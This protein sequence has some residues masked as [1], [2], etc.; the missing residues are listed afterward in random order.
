V[1]VGI[2]SDVHAN[3]AALQAAFQ[4]LERQAVQRVLVAGDLIGY[5]AQPNECL[6]ALEAAGAECVLGNH[7]LFVLDRLPPDRFPAV[8]RRSALLTRSLLT[9][10]SRAFLESLPTVL[11]RGRFVMAHG[12]LDDPEEYVTGRRRGR[13]LL[14]RVA[15]DSPGADTLV[16]G[17]THEPMYV[18][19][20]RRAVRARGSVP[21]STGRRLINPGS[22]GQSRQREARPRVRLAVMDEAAGQV[23]YFALDYDVDMSRRALRAHDLPDRC[24]HAPISVRHRAEALVRPV[25]G[26]RGWR[27]AR[28][29]YRLAGAR[30]RD[31]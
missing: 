16:L 26:D 31:G 13:E 11:A 17:H 4:H 6:A 23:E 5:G 3:L 25:L 27:T 29:L 18:D 1:R 14:A 8:A 7:D 28:R 9:E 24:L 19:E 21:L 22:V 20:R 10:R 15:T 30:D 2:L 12:S